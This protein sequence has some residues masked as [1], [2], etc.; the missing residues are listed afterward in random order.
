MKSIQGTR[1]SFGPFRCGTHSAWETFRAM[2]G[3][4][5]HAQKEFEHDQTLVTTRRYLEGWD[6]SEVLVDCSLMDYCASQKHEPLRFAKDYQVYVLRN[7]KENLRSF[8]LLLDN[9][10]LYSGT[11]TKR[12]REDSFRYCLAQL[13][14]RTHFLSRFHLLA[15]TWFLPMESLDFGLCL[16]F[17]GIGHGPVPELGKVHSLESLGSVPEDSLAAFEALFA[18]NISKVDFIRNQNVWILSS[19]R[20]ILPLDLDGYLKDF[21]C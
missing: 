12:S 5:T 6:R 17:F 11:N 4:F 1:L 10:A 9:F 21:S 13:D 3:F 15:R 14:L 8:F 7:F 20:T 16:D 2:P 18:R 19:S